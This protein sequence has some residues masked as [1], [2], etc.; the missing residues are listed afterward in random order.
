M[1]ER[2]E[3][4]EGDR[5]SDKY[6]YLHFSLRDTSKPPRRGGG[7]NPNEVPGGAVGGLQSVEACSLSAA[8]NL[9][10]PAWTQV[11]PH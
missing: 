6:V 3:T 4:R 1:R 9:T 5:T 11:H 7:G 8:R 2:D 10:E